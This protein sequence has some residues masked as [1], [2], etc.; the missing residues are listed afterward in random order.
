MAT[1]PIRRVRERAHA[2]PLDLDAHQALAH[3]ATLPPSTAAPYLTVSLDWRPEGGDP[4][5]EQAPEP[6]PSQRR[7]GRD[8]VPSEGASRRPSRQW[9]ER[10][11]ASVLAGYHPRGAAFE[12]LAADIAQV[13]AYIE[14]GLDPAAQ[15][16]YIVACSMEGVFEPLLL[17]LPLPTRL[18]VAPTPALAALAR[19]VEDY[20]TYAVLLADQLQATLSFVTQASRGLSVRLDSSDYP[21]KQQQGGW[22]QRRFQA[23]ADERVNAFARAV[24]DETRRALDE[25]G[26]P[27]LIVA[28]D[29]VITS[30]LDAALHPTVK[31]RIVA[32]IRLDN[33]A[34]EREVVEATQPIAERAERERELA[35]AR[36]VRDALGGGGA[37]A[38]GAEATLAALQ[39][40]QVKMLVVVDDFA[41]PGWADYALPLYGAGDLPSEHPAGGD[42]ADL[43]AISLEE[44]V[45]RLGL[46]SGAEIQ[47]VHSAVP[48]DSLEILEV[49][50]VGAP[51]PRSPAAVMLDEI[52]GIGAV[53]RFAI[54]GRPL[55]VA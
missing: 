10:E 4:G 15:G 25:Q 3:L 53:L 19:L 39:A 8:D 6:R 21:R 13:V 48:V 47:I 34:S 1:D 11:A 51:S 54:D 52:G 9:F 37:G 20:P 24:A 29:E 41:S 5:R 26:V 45:I 16:V 31:D 7:S 44:E 30:A 12:S 49:P 22:S 28:G 40:G 35:S 50:A 33:R 23:R 18:T 14:E 42:P 32:T 38:G 46:L 17:G 55:A 36:A 2:T 27:M 43:V